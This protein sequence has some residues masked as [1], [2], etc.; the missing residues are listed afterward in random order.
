LKSFRKS[1]FFLL[2]LACNTN[3]KKTQTQPSKM[4]QLANQSSG[5]LIRLDY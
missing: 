3:A 2:G 1:R 4:A 5:A